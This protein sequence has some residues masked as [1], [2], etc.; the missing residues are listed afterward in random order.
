MT[1]AMKH[2]ADYWPDALPVTQAAVSAA[3]S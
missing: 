1:P 2:F 3:S